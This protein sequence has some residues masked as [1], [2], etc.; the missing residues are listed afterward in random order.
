MSDDERN[1]GNQT[2]SRLEYVRMNARF[3]ARVLEV[4]REEK[5][6]ENVS[7]QNKLKKARAN[8]E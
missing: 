5:R 7:E 4:K 1:D 8:D 3:V 2:W 6:R